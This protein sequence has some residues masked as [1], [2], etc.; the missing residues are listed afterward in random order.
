VTRPTSTLR[1]RHGLALIALLP[2]LLVAGAMTFDALASNR[3]LALHPHPGEIVSVGPHDVHVLCLGEAEPTLVLQHGYGGGALDWLPLMEELAPTN[4]V[5]AVDRPGSDY[6]GPMP[7]GEWTYASALATLAA[8]LETIGV[9]RPVMVGHSLGGALAL[10]YAAEHDV[11]G[12]VLV[13]GLTADVADAVTGRLAGYGSLAPLA[14]LGLLRPLAPSFVD[15]SFEG[16]ARARLEAL[17]ARSSA[18]T[19]MAREGRAARAELGVLQLTAA[20]RQLTAPLLVV[21]AGATSVPEGRAF[22][23]ALVAFAARHDGSAYASVEGA[24]HYVMVTHAE[25]VAGAI[26][27]WLAGLVDE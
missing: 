25:E 20:E 13:D 23:D 2:V 1:R 22:T 24:G 21:A 4:R 7:T 26:R 14:R 5:C 6:S 16:E 8:T 27:S 3:A 17:R 12:L 19:A 18:I 11:R 15:G 10:L 9:V